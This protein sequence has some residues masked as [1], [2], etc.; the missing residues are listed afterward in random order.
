MA[1]V[2]R[3][4]ERLERLFAIGGGEGANRPAYSPE[5]DEA[6]AL[7]A[8]WMEEAGLEV[9]VDDAGNLLGRRGE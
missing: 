3:V 1:G 4:L 9:A 6:H 5:E 2:G 8:G 7:A